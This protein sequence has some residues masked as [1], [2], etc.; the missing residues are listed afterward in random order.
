MLRYV[1]RRVRGAPREDASTRVVSRNLL[2]FGRN[3]AR[4]SIHCVGEQSSNVLWPSGLRTYRN[5]PETP[6]SRTLQ[7]NKPRRLEIAPNNSH[8][9]RVAL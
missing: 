6:I 8:Q 4:S 7:N 9:C 3:M 5:I 1:G 2:F